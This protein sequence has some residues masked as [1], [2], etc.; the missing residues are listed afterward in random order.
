[1]TLIFVYNA[2]AGIVAG[3]MDSVHKIVSPATYACDLCA[4]TYGLASM[5]S[6]WRNWLRTLDIPV[7]FFHR[8]DFRAAWPDATI[9][10][11]AILRER[12][13]QLETLVSADEFRSITQVNQL[14]SLLEHKL[15]ETAK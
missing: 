7:Q 10:L 2:E 13:G 15:A 1:M 8:P 11:P 5:R 6:E 9:V 12:G 4:I 14:I 3:I